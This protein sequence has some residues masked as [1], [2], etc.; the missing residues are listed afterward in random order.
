MQLA[1]RAPQATSRRSVGCFRPYLR[2]RGGVRSWRRSPRGLRRSSPTRHGPAHP[3]SR[4]P[5]PSRRGGQVLGYAAAVED[6]LDLAYGRGL[7]SCV[8]YAVQIGLRGRGYA[9]V[10]A[11][12]VFA[13][14]GAGLAVEGQGDDP[15]DHDLALVDQHLVCLC[16]SLI[17]LIEWDHAGVCRDLEDGVSGGI[18]DPGPCPLLLGTQLLDDPGPRG[19]PVPQ[20][21]APRLLL[22]AT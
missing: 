4:L 22:E 15:F 6:V 2:G 19:R 3:G 14:V 5:W 21:P 8:L 18:E 1:N 11:V 17:E 9:V 13:D 10:V 12:L 16:G 20:Y 7:V